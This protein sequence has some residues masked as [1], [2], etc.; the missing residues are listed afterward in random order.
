MDKKSKKRLEVLRG[1][2]A[3]NQKLLK[4]ARAQTDDPSEIE[5]LEKQIEAIQAEIDELRGK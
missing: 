2:L 1:K 4:D 5:T 3:K